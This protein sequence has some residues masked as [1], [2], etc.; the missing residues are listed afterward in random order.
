MN[1]R[2]S[3]DVLELRKIFE[4]Q[5]TKA[6]QGGNPDRKERMNRLGRLAKIVEQNRE[7]FVEAIAADFGARSREETLIVDINACLGTISYLRGRLK[8]WMK[9]R[10]RHTSIW[11]LPGGNYTIAQPLGVVGV[12]APW[13][14]PLH[15]S[16]GP[17]AT[18]LAAG[19]S[20]MIKMSEAV[21]QTAAL[22]QRLISENFDPSVLAVTLGEA[23]FSEEFASLPFDHLFFTGSTQVG[24][25][26]MSLAAPNLTPVTLELGGKSPAIV[27]T[28]YSLEE[29]ARRIAWGKLF[30]AG[31]TCVAPDYVIV[32]DGKEMAFAKAVLEGAK[33][34]QG[35]EGASRHRTQIVNDRHFERLQRLVDD[36]VSKGAEVL[37]EFDEIDGRK[38]PL[39]LVI[40]PP[41]DCPLMQEEIFGPV[42]PIIGASSIQ[43]KLVELRHGPAPLALYYFSK[44]SSQRKKALGITRSGGVTFNDVLLHYLQDDLPF[45][46]LGASGMG[47]SHGKEGFDTFSHH[48]PV[49]TQRGLGNFTGTKLLYPPYGRLARTLI[50]TMRLI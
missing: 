16:L 1:V 46:G 44:S 38:M 47:H 42:L 39:T 29:A 18:A 11:F 9:P 37:R 5:N 23:S 32:P 21:P 25:K 33:S 36:A 41:E 7:A 48:R 12:I 15:L 19:N 14:Y 40:N 6:R 35:S 8:K 31:Q 17:A 34:M 10:R 22:L 27:D 49:F 26:V 24:R 45:G 20:V 43:D 13:N 2:V 3:P 28:D 30:N 50:R 4:D